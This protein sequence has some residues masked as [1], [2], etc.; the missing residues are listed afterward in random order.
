MRCLT[1]APPVDLN[2]KRLSE[3]MVKRKKKMYVRNDVVY[4]PNIEFPSVFDFEYQDVVNLKK[5][6]HA[7]GGKKKLWKGP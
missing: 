6:Y 2:G 3:T 7:K 1:S 5:Q 4:D